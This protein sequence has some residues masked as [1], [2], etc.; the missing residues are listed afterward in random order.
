[1]EEDDLFCEAHETQQEAEPVVT[2][3]ATEEQQK[4]AVSPT[5]QRVESETQQ[6]GSVAQPKEKEAGDGRDQEVQWCAGH[7][8]LRLR[9]DGLREGIARERDENYEDEEV[10]AETSEEGSEELSA[11]A[12]AAEDGADED[13]GDDSG[14]GSDEVCVDCGVAWALCIIR[15]GFGDVG[16]ACWECVA[17]VFVLAVRIRHLWL[18]TVPIKKYIYI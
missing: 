13:C 15:V 3:N 14:L 1:M 12:A 9:P 6:R 7:V 4:P 2:N 16:N 8:C 18:G 11:A 17:V 10:S 5:H